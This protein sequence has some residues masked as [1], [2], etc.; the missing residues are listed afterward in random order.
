MFCACLFVC[1]FDVPTLPVKISQQTL[2]QTL[3]ISCL[4]SPSCSCKTHLECCNPFQWLNK[5]VIYF[6]FLCKTAIMPNG[7]YAKRHYAKWGASA[8]AGAVLCIVCKSY[9]NFRSHIEFRSTHG[10]LIFSSTFIQYFSFSETLFLY[11]KYD[12]NEN[13]N[14]GETF[15]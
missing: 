3:D 9:K 1:T 6:D 11:D 13:Q 5:T 10:A 4:S 15:L 14:M 2:T 7:H 8:S 12:S